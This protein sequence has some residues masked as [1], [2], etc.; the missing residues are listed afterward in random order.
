MASMAVLVLGLWATPALGHHKDGHDNGQSTES[1][2]TT[3]QNGNAGGSSGS[4]SKANR[5][6]GSSTQT[7]T[8]SG[9]GVSTT[10]ANGA[11]GDYCNTPGQQSGNGNNGGNKN[12][13]A[14]T[15]GNADNKNPPGQFKNGGDSNNGYECD[16]NSGVARGN[17]AHSGCQ[18][19]PPPP[20]T[21][22]NP[23]CPPPNGGTPPSGSTEILGSSTERVPPPSGKGSGRQLAFTGLS[24][25]PLVASALGLAALGGGLV[26]TGRKR[27]D[28]S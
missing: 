17:P 6:S 23:N 1:T 16:G 3:T 12:H 28:E 4:N 18:E 22:P 7:T 20:C 24:T 21:P 10:S 19:P 14:G 27:E 15:V 11:C 25:I 9:S 26:F 8:T 13:G 5:S 2:D